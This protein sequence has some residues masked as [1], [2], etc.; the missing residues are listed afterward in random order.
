MFV[1]S[2][3]L[4]GVQLFACSLAYLNWTGA[5]KSYTQ[6][7]LTTGSLWMLFVVI[8]LCA[9]PCFV[10]F[11]LVDTFRK[12]KRQIF[13]LASFQITLNSYNGWLSHIQ[14][15]EKRREEKSSTKM[16]TTVWEK[17]HHFSWKPSLKASIYILSLL[18][19]FPFKCALYF[20]LGELKQ[21]TSA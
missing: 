8:C 14:E 1:V 3:A 9:L 4:L 12:N 15:V 7:E 11:K 18:S 20:H 17:F 21:P 5:K 16:T 2:F 19:T 6:V 10:H 13:P